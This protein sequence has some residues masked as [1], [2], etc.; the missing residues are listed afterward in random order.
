MLIP[1]LEV[2]TDEL[3][4]FY[5]GDALRRAHFPLIYLTHPNAKHN[6]TLNMI[7]GK[8]SSASSH[9]FMRYMLELK[10]EW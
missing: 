1:K 6:S 10:W 2:T 9:H 7:S 3:S 4:Y 5:V 8:W